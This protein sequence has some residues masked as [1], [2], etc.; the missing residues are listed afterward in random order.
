MIIVLLLALVAACSAVDVVTLVQDLESG[1]RGSQ[2]LSREF[3]EFAG[4]VYLS[5]RG[6]LGQELYR[7]TPAGDLVS[8]AD[9]SHA[10]QLTMT[11]SG[12]RV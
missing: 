1:T 2:Q 3:V 4:A 6:P 9:F 8:L 5:A 12:A 10:V 7:H 11:S